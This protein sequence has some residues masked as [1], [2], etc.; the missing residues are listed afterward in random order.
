MLLL[1]LLAGG[2]SLLSGGCR[3]TARSHLEAA[4]AFAG[5]LRPEEYDPPVRL[6]ILEELDAAVPK[7]EEAGDRA[8][9]REALLFRAQIFSRTGLGDRAVGDLRQILER[10]DPQDE[11]ALR[12]LGVLHE[13]L[14]EEERAIPYLDRVLERR[15]DDAVALFWSADAF[16]R[17]ANR[18][19]ERL[20]ERLEPLLAQRQT[21]EAA[22]TADALAY[23]P[24]SDPRAVRLARELE[25][26][27]VPSGLRATVL[28]AIDASRTA[29]SEALQR[30]RR[31]FRLQPDDPSLRSLEGLLL[32]SYRAG[33]E[34]ETLAALALASAV[35]SARR[36][37]E[38]A[39]AAGLVGVHRLLPPPAARGIS[40]LSVEPVRHL[41]RLP[42]EN[43][44]LWSV[45]LPLSP[46]I[47]ERFVD[48]RDLSSFE[49]MARSD[50]FRNWGPYD[51]VLGFLL[52]YLTGVVR[53]LR[54]DLDG[55]VAPLRDAAS[56]ADRD[57][58]RGAVAGRLLARVA[59]VRRDLPLLREA[60][61]GLLALDEDD[62]D[63]FAVRGLGEL[64]LGGEPGEAAGAL[65][66]AIE[67]DPGAGADLARPWEEAEAGEQGALGR[68]ASTLA[69]RLVRTR[70]SIDLQVPDAPLFLL[71]ARALE[72]FERKEAAL[73][74]AQE[75]AFRLGAFLPTTRALGL[76]Q[77]RCG[78]RAEG[79]ETLRSVLALAPDDLESLR[80]CVSLGPEVPREATV[81]FLDQAPPSEARAL[82]AR[83][84]LGR[85]DAERALS[86]LEPEEGD[87]EA[88][89]IRAGAL[90]ALGRNEAA[91]ERLGRLSP[92]RLD[93]LLLSGDWLALAAATGEARDAASAAETL[94]APGVPGPKRLEGALRLLALGFAGEVLRLVPEEEGPDA[95]RTR[96]IAL[97]LRRDLLG[98]RDALD[99]AHGLGSP[100]AARD[101]ELL[102]LV[103]GDLLPPVRPRKGAGSRQETRGGSPAGPSTGTAE[104]PEVRFVRLAEDAPGWESLLLE[105]TA[106][107]RG[108]PFVAGARARALLRSG[109]AS[110]A[111]EEAGALLRRDPRDASALEVLARACREEGWDPLARAPAAD[112]PAG[113]R[114]ASL[115]PL[116]PLAA[117]RALRGRALGGDRSFDGEDLIA[118]M[119]ALPPAL[120]ELAAEDAA[121]L[122][123]RARDEF[124]GDRAALA[125]RLPRVGSVALLAASNLS[126]SERRAALA[127]LGEELRKGSLSPPSPRFLAAALPALL[128]ADPVSVGELLAALRELDPSDPGLLR[129][130]ADFFERTGDAVRS[131]AL[132]R[133]EA[134]FFGGG[135]AR[136]AVARRIARRGP[137]P[138]EDPRSWVRPLALLDGSPTRVG[139]EVRAEGRGEEGAIRAALEAAARNDAGAEG[140]ALEAWIPSGADREAAETLRAE[141]ALRRGALAEAERW[142]QSAGAAS[143]TPSALLFQALALVFGGRGAEAASLLESAPEAIERA[144]GP[145]REALLDLRQGLAPVRKP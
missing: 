54:G 14:A 113:T 99:R 124:R 72:S 85:G 20:R 139:T 71:V 117:W 48:G 122:L 77:V 106:S 93:P 10:I 62:A 79:A 43:P 15:P 42:S 70:A 2:G 116:D 119:E 35:P 105:R 88:E 57:R 4:R 45:I 137:V 140:E 101:L 107:R 126:G 59:Y 84:R 128:D 18:R 130:H 41:L 129:A 40:P 49:G 74:N 11:T 5:S 83:L 65:R 36:D 120:R 29:R 53:V 12:D 125:E 102:S 90:R 22:E 58:A 80:A 123:F 111:I 104:P 27:S 60:A 87:P 67:L 81:L 8:L 37:P 55:A 144:E 24:S 50:F 127:K 6:R 103:A 56:R 109:R 132:A 92:E 145:L 32:L 89:R 75:A 33:L 96:G 138:A 133:R 44:K 66:R 110:A 16:R 135:E 136:L 134:E 51:S 61:K 30:Y 38:T 28:E 142:A 34:E 108:E 25:K 9:L 63:A 46:T 91:R 47:L 64:R 121:L 13:S 1:G 131:F 97:L 68:Q 73:R 19:I 3:R 94:L 115:A 52:P 26:G 31:S 82:L 17:R 78:R 21:R 98:A 39:L 76:M 86:L 95:L 69:E 143:P 114:P 118:V 100:L 7:A 112:P 23:L 141:A